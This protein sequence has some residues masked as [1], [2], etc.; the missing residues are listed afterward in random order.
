MAAA[1]A[2]QIDKAELPC[3]A[4]LSLR[5]R[6]GPV[7]CYA[8]LSTHTCGPPTL[9]QYQLQCDAAF[10]VKAGSKASFL[11]LCSL[12]LCLFAPVLL[13][14]CPRIVFSLNPVC[15]AEAGGP[16]CFGQVGTWMVLL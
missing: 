16:S 14:L 8:V 7:P 11:C 10:E 4:V 13:A 2:A 5:L 9:L 12:H 6:S 3:Y 15:L 1:N